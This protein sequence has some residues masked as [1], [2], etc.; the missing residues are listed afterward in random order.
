MALQEG[1]RYE[2]SDPDCGCAIQVSKGA[3]PGKGGNQAPRW[4][5]GKEM[6]KM[7]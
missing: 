6:R 5:C 1:E 7:R 2:C 4:C 3:A